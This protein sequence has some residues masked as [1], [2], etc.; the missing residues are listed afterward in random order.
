ML[1][2]I[3]MLTLIVDVIDINIDGGDGGRRRRGGID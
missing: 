2:F 3:V 1:V